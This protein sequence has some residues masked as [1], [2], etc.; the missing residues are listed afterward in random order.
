MSTDNAKKLLGLNDLTDGREDIEKYFY[1][2]AESLGKLGVTDYLDGFCLL[3]KDLKGCKYIDG[4]SP[5]FADAVIAD[6]EKQDSEKIFFHNPE[7]ELGVI[8]LPTKD[9]LI[10]T[11]DMS[12]SLSREKCIVVTKNMTNIVKYLTDNNLMQYFESTVS[13]DDVEKIKI[14]TRAETIGK[15]NGDMLPMFTAGYAT[16]EEVKSNDAQRDQVNHTFVNYVKNSIENKNTIQ[17]VLDNALLYGYNGNDDRVVEVTY[18]DGSIAT[19]AI[20]AEVYNKLN[21]K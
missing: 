18:N 15:K 9:T 17:T 8:Y 12:L 2:H 21:I 5:D 13:A 19:Y 10:G 7:D 4:L 3:T 14:A 11:S 20:K 1:Y 6:L 16:A